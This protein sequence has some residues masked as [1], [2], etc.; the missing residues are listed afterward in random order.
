MTNCQNKFYISLAAEALALRKKFKLYVLEKEYYKTGKTGNKC[1]C[2]KIITNGNVSYCGHHSNVR[3]KFFDRFLME[4]SM[5]NFILKSILGFLGGILLTY[6][7][8][9]FFVFSL[10][11]TLKRATY[12]CIGLGVILS[13]GLAFSVKIRCTVFL[14]IP[15]LF[16]KRGRQAL[17][18]YAF[19]L[20]LSGPAKNT[21]HNV[22]VMS[23]SLACG[24]EQI[25]EA[26]N[27]LLK[28]VQRPN[29]AAKKSLEKLLEKL[30]NAVKN[31]R[32][33]ILQFYRTCFDVCEYILTH[34]SPL[35]VKKIWSIHLISVDKWSYSI[36]LLCNNE[37]GEPKQRCHNLLDETKENC[38]SSDSL[39]FWK[40]LCSISPRKRDLICGS[41][42]GRL[43]H[44][45]EYPQEFSIDYL[46]RQ[47]ENFKRR[48]LNILY[49]KVH[50]RQTYMQSN[51]SNTLHE[52]YQ[53]MATEIRQKTD[54]FLQYF[55]F[56]S[57]IFGIF[58][59]VLFVK[60]IIYRH[61]FLTEDHYDNRFITP[62]FVD[63]DNT[64]AEF[65]METILPLK[66]RERSQY[67]KV[68]SIRLVPCE[69]V[70]LLSSIIFLIFAT[71]KI[72]IHMLTDSSLYWILSS[73]R[74]NERL[75]YM[76][77]LKE[78]QPEVVVRINGKGIVAAIFQNISYAVKKQF[79][80]PKL[81][82][83][84]CLPDPVPP[85]WNRYYQILALVLICWL[86]AMFEPYGLRLRHTVMV[87]YHP[88]R[89]RERAIW[90][91][92]RIISNRNS[93]VKVARREMRRK[94]KNTVE[95]PK[96]RGKITANDN[97]FK[98]PTE[99]CV[100]VFCKDCF[101]ILKY[102]SICT[103]PSK[104]GDM[105]D[106]SE[107]KDSSSD[108]GY[109]DTKENKKNQ[110]EKKK[111]PVKNAESVKAI[112]Q[113][114]SRRPPKSPKKSHLKPVMSR[115]TTNRTTRSTI[116]DLES[117][118]WE[119]PGEVEEVLEQME[120]LKRKVAKQGE[121]SK[122]KVQG[123]ECEKKSH[124]DRG[125]HSKMEEQIPGTSQQARND[126]SKKEMNRNRSKTNL[127]EKLEIRL[128]ERFSQKRMTPESSSIL[129]KVQKRKQ[130][131]F[132]FKPLKKTDTIGS[133]LRVRS[134]VELLDKFHSSKSRNS[135]M[136]SF[137]GSALKSVE[138]FENDSNSKSNTSRSVRGPSMS[139][140]FYRLLH[141]KR[142]I[143][144][145][146]DQQS[147][148]SNTGVR[149]DAEPEN[150]GRPETSGLQ[151]RTSQVNI[152]NSSLKRTTPLK[153]GTNKEGSNPRL[154]AQKRLSWAPDLLSDLPKRHSD[155]SSDSI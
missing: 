43:C 30:N 10:N 82:P 39:L 88:D 153:E 44:P 53:G 124:D 23:E 9:M 19:I 92:N 129:L 119:S 56:M 150:D 87:T 49:V 81:D 84:P 137:K 126:V 33:F 72:V 143:Q 48:A 16:S 4:D 17:L 138:E 139:E 130:P 125:Q 131:D 77:S 109:T 31:F 73:V 132:L 36:A 127:K 50:V 6:I 42:T 114:D 111:S 121:T 123:K 63:I 145:P 99:K 59:L 101:E 32:K 98:C 102:C 97:H 14:C 76:S 118:E 108:D 154:S 78:Q 38:E 60:V 89:A 26:E 47:L 104:Y 107:E 20:A 34:K 152:S 69:K 13:L 64:R 3:N 55:D 79:T 110:K 54:Q 96:L 25:K 51:R 120:H 113:K 41:S 86:L 106:L 45:A 22:E 155:G 70:R 112:F 21:L 142:K 61:K 67:I 52:E 151:S 116:S 115:S 94:Y 83:T 58:I 144:E 134:S 95:V 62:D 75:L 29:A 117:S 37:M 146:T 12:I 140:D 71:F 85:D 103:D 68:T 18:A 27:E 5:Q 136:K 1:L 133:F 8:F 135:S 46:Q 15:Q 122:S 149:K 57:V 141:P 11:F 80:L 40:L 148:K 90:L 74:R 65:Q 100:G 66:P 35:A 93:Y 147:V 128:S 24:Q 7:C 91:Y 105:S 2:P 28:C